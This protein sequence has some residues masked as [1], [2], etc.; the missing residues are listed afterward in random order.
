[1]AEGL[2]GSLS[3]IPL[4]DLLRMFAAGAQTGRL[5]LNAG[6]NAGDVYVQHGD[7][8]H[9]EAESA[10]GDA[11]FIK[12]LGWANASFRF[13]PGISPM[14]RTIEKTLDVLVADAVKAVAEREAIR[15]VIPSTDAIPRLAPELPVPSITIDALDWRILARMD[16]MTSISMVGR[17]LMMEEPELIKHLVRLK[18]ANLFELEIVQTQPRE[19]PPRQLVN[20][21][22]FQGLTVAVADAMGP[23]AEVIIDDALEAMGFTRATLPRD[24]VSHLCERIAMEIRDDTHRVRFQQT[25]LAMLRNR[26][27]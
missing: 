8:V 21:Q 16:G 12:M 7:I 6:S 27:A 5:R 14:D 23:L 24:H 17:E 22:F 18:N 13:E 4:P 19:A 15:R 9:A 2:S 3:Q 11:A 1:M 10:M 25:M 26:A 20:A